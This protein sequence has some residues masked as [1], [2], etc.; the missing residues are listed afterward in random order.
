M[1]SFPGKNHQSSHSEIKG[2]MLLR[3][4]AILLAVLLSLVSVG[5]LQRVTAQGKY[6]LSLNGAGAYV[7]VPNSASL[8]ITGPITLEAWIKTNSNVTQQGIIERYNWSTVDDG[9]Y[10][11]RLSSSGK[12]QFFTQ[13]NSSAYDILTGSTTVTTGV[14]H[15]VAGVFDG[16]QMRIYLNGVLDGSKASTLA[17][18]AG[19][20]S[21]KIGARGNDV[22]YTFN[23]LIDEARVT[24]AALYSGNFTPQVS[25]TAVTGTR[26]LWKFDNQSTSDSSGNG[27]NGALVGG[28]TFSTDV[29]GGAVSPTSDPRSVSGAWSS[30]FSWPF[31]AIHMNVLPN[32]K[33]LAWEQGPQAR[34]WDPATNTFTGVPMYMTDLLCTGHSFLPDGRLLVTG[35]HIQS[36]I[37]EPDSNIFNPSNNTWSVGP[38]MNAPRWYPTNCTLPKGE[39]LVV[40]GSIDNNLIN[41]L[42]QVWKTTGGWRD[43]TTARLS[44][45]A[46]PSLYPWMFVA[47]NGKVFNSGPD[48]ITRYLDTSG[49]GAWS[50]VGYSNS[51]SRDD[52]SSVMYGDGKVLIVGGGDPPTNTA[53]VIDL[54]VSSPA[55]QRVGS[56]VYAR[57]HLNATLLPDGKVLVTGGSS[58]SGFNDETRPVYAAEMWDPATARWSTMAS[59]TV[60]R[61]YHSAA[62]L[63]PDGRVLSAGGGGTGGG[64]SYYNVEF[65]SPPYLFKGA[66]PTISSAPTSVGYG[67]TFFVGTPNATSIS[68]VNWIRLGS[69]THAFDQNQ[70]INRLIFT[71]A[72]GGLNVTA[73]SRRNLCPPGHYMLF[74]LNGNGVPS[75]A[76]IVKIG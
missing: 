63:L 23:G 20:V 71:Q 7:N 47:P 11:L 2:R 27:N 50:T 64:T 24:A 19:T 33:V 8:N 31:V 40:S 32:G 13:R 15:H 34:V 29:P 55:W 6:S 46:S 12:L 37:G 57:R 21:L 54:N 42:P 44:M 73:P 53:E 30:P 10:G 36:R 61:F 45:P 26:G 41:D 51:G 68:K 59:M 67:Q 69:V 60:P 58:G 22:A 72:S 76:R 14:W 75:V 17:P 18:A 62:I 9:G 66:R 3:F 5:L 70:R 28:A 1:T 48:K 16:T 35:G 49:T 25:L 52:G 65:Y 56:M 38:I 74:I 43:L 39:V 4:C